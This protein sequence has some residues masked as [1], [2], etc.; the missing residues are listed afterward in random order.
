MDVCV[1]TRNCF[2]NI[3]FSIPLYVP[4][5]MFVFRNNS[6]DWTHNMCRII[7]WIIYVMV[8]SY[9]Q[10]CVFWVDFWHFPIRHLVITLCNTV[11]TILGCVCDHKKL[12]SKYSIQYS[13]I[14][15][16]ENVWFQK[17]QHRLNP[18]S[19]WMVT[20]IYSLQRLIFC[21]MYLV[22]FFYCLFLYSKNSQETA[23]FTLWY[24]YKDKVWKKKLQI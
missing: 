6:T 11:N 19:T 13:L 20:S 22:R 7:Y 18:N 23:S 24:I 16:G 1:T 2:P 17:Q 3:V 8:S 12:F 15:T 10:S 21:I 4:E 5:K 9:N 14:C